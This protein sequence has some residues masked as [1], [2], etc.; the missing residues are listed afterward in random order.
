MSITLAWQTTEDD[1][2]A[3]LSDTGLDEESN[4]G[5][6]MDKLDFSKI[7]EAALIEDDEY[8]EDMEIQTYYANQEIERQIRN[9]VHVF[10]GV[11][12]SLKYD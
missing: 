8:G 4:S 6:Y 2:K 3:V 9:I 10:T 7:E 11:L 5:F 1:I 12:K